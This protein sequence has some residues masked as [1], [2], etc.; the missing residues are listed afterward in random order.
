MKDKIRRKWSKIGRKRE[1]EKDKK[2]EKVRNDRGERKVKEG[3][4]E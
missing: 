4:R 2:G 1:R 3:E